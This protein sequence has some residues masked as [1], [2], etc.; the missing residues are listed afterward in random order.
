VNF[1]TYRWREQELD[2]TGTIDGKRMGFVADALRA[3]SYAWGF[4]DQ[5]FSSATNFLLAV[6][7]G[8]VLGPAGLAAVMVGFTLYLVALSFQR[9]LVTEPLVASSTT[10]HAGQRV[11]SA[12]AALVV[13]LVGSLLATAAELGI[14]GLVGG[15]YGQGIL[16]V[17]VWLPFALVQDFWRTI[18][19]RDER[20]SA[21]AVNDGLWLAVMGL[22]IP[23]AW[24][25][26]SSWA[27]AGCWG[28]GALAGT[29]AGVVQTRIRPVSPRL[30]IEWWRREAAALGKW[31]GL[32]SLASNIAAYSSVFML[33][34]LLSAASYG[35][36]RAVQT[37]FGPLSL[38]YPAVA[39]PGLPAIA[40]AHTESSQDA[41]SLAVRLS[42]LVTALTVLYVI[43]FTF[44]SGAL[45]LLFGPEFAR[46]H[47]LTLPVGLAQITAATS[48]GFVLL[49]KAQRRGRA[50]FWS[51]IFALVLILTIT[52]SLAATRGV[53]AVAWGYFAAA[54]PAALLLAIVALRFEPERTG[55]LEPATP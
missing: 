43:V 40:R 5:G 9:S 36:L 27:I 51:R 1:P 47:A 41:R 48:V 42:V 16:V 24:L 15:R 45:P 22:A 14:A 52:T 33:V 29:V 4:V 13:V 12:R 49:L 19:F 6:V 17:A 50:L 53:T 34:A 26:G 28:L 32:E 8:R 18:L 46:F 37:V 39:L 25:S 23:F 7:A 2:D 31:L 30:A 55:R 38:L 10:H 44:A 54:L 21:A 20:A 35:G 3:R 11:T